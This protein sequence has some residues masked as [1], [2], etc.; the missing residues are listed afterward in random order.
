[1]SGTTKY[2]LIVQNLVGVR[3]HGTVRRLYD[4]TRL[5]ALGVVSRNHAVQR[6]GHQHIARQ[7]QQLFV[8]NQFGVAVGLEAAVAPRAV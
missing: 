5:D 1:M 8:G 2:A 7:F 3:R 4:D 6:G